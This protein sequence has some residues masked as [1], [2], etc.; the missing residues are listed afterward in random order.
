MYEIWIQAPFSA[1][2]IGLDLLTLWFI[3]QHYSLKKLLWG[4]TVDKLTQNYRTVWMLL[5]MH[6]TFCTGILISKLKLIRAV[7]INLIPVI[8]SYVF[9]DLVCTCWFMFAG[10]VEAYAGSC[11]STLLT[12]FPSLAYCP[13]PH[14]FIQCSPS[15]SLVILKT[16]MSQSN[17]NILFSSI[18]LNFISLSFTI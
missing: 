15:V 8:L 2:L 14:V 7:F 10:H 18:L 5:L 9:L 12:V 13:T 11:L 4:F 6:K 3:D 17:V 16:C 1:I